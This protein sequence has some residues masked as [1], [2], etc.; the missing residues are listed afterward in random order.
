LIYDGEQAQL[1]PI[2]GCAQQKVQVS[3]G[4]L[5]D[6]GTLVQ[7]MTVVDP[8]MPAPGEPLGALG[9]RPAA[10]IATDDRF[11]LWS[12]LAAGWAKDPS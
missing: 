1:P 6:L 10:A 8:P 12:R 9:F 5:P 4:V 11:E 2:P 7:L 3:H